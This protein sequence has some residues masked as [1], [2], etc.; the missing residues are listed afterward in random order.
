MKEKKKLTGAVLVRE[1]DQVVRGSA[2]TYDEAVWLAL[3]LSAEDDDELY[4]ILPADERLLLDWTLPWQRFC[5]ERPDGRRV[6]IA[7]ARD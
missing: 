7:V 1:C 3:Q 2:R 4:E 6:D 5:W